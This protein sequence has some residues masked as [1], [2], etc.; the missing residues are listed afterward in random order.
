MEIR[1]EKVVCM[2]D[3]TPTWRGLVPL[4]ITAITDGSPTAK[5]AAREELYRLADF[6]DKIN[7]ERKAD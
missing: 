2:V 7:A 4:L 5:S 3:M 6:A 1:G